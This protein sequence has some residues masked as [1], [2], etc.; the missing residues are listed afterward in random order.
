MDVVAIVLVVVDA[1]VLHP[2]SGDCGKSSRLPR[3]MNATSAI[4][5]SSGMDYGG[6]ASLSALLLRLVDAARS[7]VNIKKVAAQY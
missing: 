2:D 3:S 5:E 1:V 6:L 7:F 4:I